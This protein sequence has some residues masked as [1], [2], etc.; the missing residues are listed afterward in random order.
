MATLLDFL[1]SSVTTSY[2]RVPT[3]LS[4][5]AF[6]LSLVGLRAGIKRTVSP[7]LSSARSLLWLIAWRSLLVSSFSWTFWSTTGLRSRG[8]VGTWV[9]VRLYYWAALHSL[10]RRV[11]AFEQ[12]KVRICL[13]KFLHNWLCWFD[14]CLNFPVTLRVCRGACRV[15]EAPMTNELLHPK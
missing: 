15:S 8:K 10:T 9:L 2:D 3:D 13:S 14:S 5:L 7:L 1:T 11:P 12:C 4:T 6:T